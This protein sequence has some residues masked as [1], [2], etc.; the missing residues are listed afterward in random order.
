M[1]GEIF[2]GLSNLAGAAMDSNSVKNTNKLNARLA[3]Y[4]NQWNLDM[5]NRQNEYNSPLAQMQRLKDAGLNPNM[6]YGNGSAANQAGNVARAEVP[7]LQA[8][9]GMQQAMN[10]ASSAVMN[11][12]LTSAQIKNLEEQ[13]NILKVDAIA[14]RQAILQQNIQMSKQIMENRAFRDDYMSARK[15]VELSVKQ[16]HQDLA[17]SQVNERSL[18]ANVQLTQ[19]RVQTELLRPML[20][21]AE[22]NSVMAK[23]PGIVAESAVSKKAAYEYEEYGIRPSDPIWARAIAEALEK[24]RAEV[25]GKPT[26]HQTVKRWVREKINQLFSSHGYGSNF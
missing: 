12:L 23:L 24:T 15:L 14:K 7:H 22:Y 13:N 9:Q 10:G 5:W 20:S 4:Q 1:L 26:A 21:Q 3:A 18:T 16:A 8:Y 17:N 25:T 6:V 11:S 2:L 19:A